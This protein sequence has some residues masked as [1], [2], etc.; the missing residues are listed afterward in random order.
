M[1]NPPLAGIVIREIRDFFTSNP[2]LLVSE[3]RLAT[4]L[5][6]P[7]HLVREAVRILEGEGLLERRDEDTLIGLWEAEERSPR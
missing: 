4:L 1:E 7:P 5:C 2:F 6:R 3:R